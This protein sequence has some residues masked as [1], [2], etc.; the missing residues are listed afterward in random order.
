MIWVDLE[1]TGLDFER[2]RI[3]E[4]A[5]LVTNAELEIIAEGPNLVIHQSDELLSGMDEWNTRHHGESG[6]TERVRASTVTEEE[7]E[8]DLLAFVTAHTVAQKAPLAGNSI[9]QD[10]LFLSRYMPTFTAH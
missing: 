5:V 8:A 2:E 4:A 1:M 9:H 6:L 3:I 7:A 10:R